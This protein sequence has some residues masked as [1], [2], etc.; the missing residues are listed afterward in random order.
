MKERGIRMNLNEFNQPIGDKVN[1]FFEGKKPEIVEIIGK[2]AII[3]KL[4]F[5]NHFEDLVEVYG[6][7]NDLKNWTYFPLEPFTN[8]NELKKYLEIIEK[9]EDPYFLSIL[10]KKTKKVL[11]TFALM[12]IDAKNR[13]IEIGWILYSPELK[14]SRIATEAQYLVMKYVFETLQYRRYEWKC[15]NLNESSKNS[16]LRLGFTKEGIFRQAQVYKGRNRDTAWFSILDKEWKDN[17][18]RFEEWLRE[19]NFDENGNQIK[20][21]SGIRI[22]DEI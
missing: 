20:S 9:S 4:S 5:K 10:D 6:L 17:K 12:R 11:G 3:E 7:E 21:L 19:E 22:N 1:N 14:R 8:R 16:A 15:D 18:K 13:V 2:Y